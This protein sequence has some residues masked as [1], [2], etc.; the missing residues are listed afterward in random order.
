MCIGKKE[1]NYFIRLF[2]AS[3]S[4]SKLEGKNSRT[5]GKGLN[6][7]IIELNQDLKGSLELIS[8]TECLLYASSLRGT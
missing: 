5:Q 2:I 7:L 8:K 4:H 6:N 3:R 1:K